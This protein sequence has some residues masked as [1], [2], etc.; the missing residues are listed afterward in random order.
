MSITEATA[1]VP[2]WTLGDRLAKAREFAGIKT[3]TDMGALM[4]V[5]EKTIRTW[6]NGK[7]RIPRHA[8]VAWSQFTG[9]DLNW[10]EHGTIP[11]E[12]T[13]ADIQ[14]YPAQNLLTTLTPAA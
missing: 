9:V 3:V 12:D 2:V 11:V 7:H 8:I 5:T 14:R 13:G 4:G 10:L 6:E 1:I